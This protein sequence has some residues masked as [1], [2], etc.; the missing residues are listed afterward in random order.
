MN[1]R[2]TGEED[3]NTREECVIKERGGEREKEVREEGCRGL[4]TQIDT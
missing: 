4:H 2:C 1:Y 3:K